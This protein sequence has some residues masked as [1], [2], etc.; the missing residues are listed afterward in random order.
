MRGAIFA[1]EDQG[2]YDYEMTCHCSAVTLLGL[3][4]YLLIDLFDHS[5]KKNTST[6]GV[7]RDGAGVNLRVDENPARAGGIDRQ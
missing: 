2:G 6:Q 4:T 7:G 3:F 1:D 5:I